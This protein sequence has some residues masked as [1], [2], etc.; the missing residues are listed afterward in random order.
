[1]KFN[2]DS[3]QWAN[4][5]EFGLDFNNSTNTKFDFSKMCKK[6]GGAYLS[7]LESAYKAKEKMNDFDFCRTNGEIPIAFLEKIK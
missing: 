7:Y 4:L 5:L 1:M 3:K 2:C 6:F